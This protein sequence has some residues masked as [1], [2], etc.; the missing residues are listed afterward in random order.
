MKKE[1]K[2][3]VET[4]TLELAVRKFIQKEDLD[5]QICSFPRIGK[6]DEEACIAW[7]WLHKKLNPAIYN[8]E[9][10]PSSTT[11][12]YPNIRILSITP[13]SEIMVISYADT[14]QTPKWVGVDDKGT[15]LE[16]DPEK[17]LNNEKYIEL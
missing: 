5:K 4:L 14:S 1:Q 6:T 7:L 12:Y 9:F 15:L 11:N 17:L 8:V 2:P 13:M 10:N 3:I 16:A